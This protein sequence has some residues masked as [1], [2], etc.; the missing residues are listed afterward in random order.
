MRT[1]LLFALS[2]SLVA[3]G[4]LAQ[5]TSPYPVP[6]S[7]AAVV[8]QSLDANSSE[9]ITFSEYAVGTLITDQYR[10]IGILFGA[11]AF[12]SP[13]GSNP[14]SPV[15][16]G[17]PRFQGDITG[18]FVKPGTNDSVVVRSFT[19]DAGYFNEIGSTRIEWFDPE[20]NKIGQAINSKLGIETF[21][22]AGGNIAG[23]KISVVANEPAGYAIDN[24]S[25]VPIGPSVLFRENFTDRKEG[26]WEFLGDEIPGFDHV[27]FHIDNKVYESHPGYLA[28]TYV[29]ADG[30]E[31]VNVAQIDGVQS[32]H[33]RAT[34]AHDARLGESS[35]V[36]TFEE[37]PI[38]EQLAEKMR[39]AINTVRGYT[40]RRI[41][42]SFPDGLAK[43]L[44]PAAQKGGDQ[45]FTCVGLV[46]WAAEQAGHNGG[47]GFIPSLMESVLIPDPRDLSKTIEVPFLSPQ[48]LNYSMK[49]S[50]LVADA[51]QLVQGLI[52]PVDF[53]ITDPL[54]RRLGAVQ[55]VGAYN[56]IPYAFYPGDGDVEQILI[57]AAV[58]G[59]Y[60]LRLVGTGDTTF[61]AV[62]ALGASASFYGFLAEGQ[63]VEREFIVEPRP[64]SAGD[65]NIDGKVNGLD[66]TALI[67]KLNTFTAG[68]GDPGDLD[69]DGLLSVEDLE[70]LRKLI[71]VQGPGT[72]AGTVF[73]FTLMNADTDRRVPAFTILKDGDVIDLSKLPTQNVNIRAEVTPKRVGSVLFNLDG[74]IVVENNNPYCYAANRG[75]DYFAFNLTPGEHT[76]TATPYSE[77][78]PYDAKEGK[79]VKGKPLTIKFKVIGSAVT[80][81]VLLNAETDED[82]DTL[83]AGQVID[84]ADL[85]TQYVN[86]RA[87]TTPDTVGS[88][89]FRLNNA[90]PV[91][92]NYF[93]YA[94]GGDVN[95]NFR[96]WTLPTGQHTLT[97]TPYANANGTGKAG[98]AHSVAF[99]VVNSE[100]GGRRGTEAFPALPA[101]G[102]Q[103]SPNPFSLRTTVRFS[104][105]QTGPAR[106]VLHAPNGLP[107]SALF[108]GSAEAGKVYAVDLNSDG[109]SSG[110]YVLRLTSN[111]QVTNHKLVL[112]K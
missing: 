6:D 21:T 89:V 54:G 4:S 5:S 10:D 78:T 92:E 72:E 82:I 84:L 15:L 50:Q 32:E 104:V 66:T 17:T 46:E 86:I 43:T 75:S 69:G 85:P 61:S 106:L 93:P 42:F 109:L 73:S 59:R 64:G 81:L 62:A 30:E 47:E 112:I 33:S 36:K 51:K 96:F 3:F 57:P 44:S 68:L 20:G 25:F 70:L 98:A 63:V 48:L 101:E 16:S 11:G 58:P 1:I 12:I 88:V 103:A 91:R 110:V 23:W 27:G 38:D 79:G 41:S 71:N 105:P 34:F 29:S 100:A 37:I 35:P 90:A 28:G 49:V 60:V 99:Q 87:V 22:L 8:V 77:Y 13:D 97:A 95:G 40:F 108:T 94:I 76:L 80:R 67:P 24:F 65:V 9:V 7:A 56:E 111:Q 19:F 45:S 74:N 31:K 53:V 39:T 107:L 55:G 2:F 52:D 83:H 102:I 18:W 26:T 14:T